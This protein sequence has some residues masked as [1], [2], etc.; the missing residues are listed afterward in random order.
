[1]TRYIIQNDNE[2]ICCEALRVV[3]NISRDKVSNNHFDMALILR[4]FCVD[5]AQARMEVQY[6]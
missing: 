5:C 3:S 2:D 4:S 6:I 1:M